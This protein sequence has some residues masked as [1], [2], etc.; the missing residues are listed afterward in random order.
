MDAGGLNQTTISNAVWNTATRSLTIANG[1]I[2]GQTLQAVAILSNLDMTVVATTNIVTFSGAVGCVMVVGKKC[3][4]TVGV[5]NAT[6]FIDLILDGVTSSFDLY[7]GAVGI[8][9]SSQGSVNQLS[10]TGNQVT[11][12]DFCNWQFQMGFN[13]SMTVRVR[14]TATTFTLL[15]DSFTVMWT[16]V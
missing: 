11:I 3:T 15:K 14:I 13:N 2:T 7:D 9:A 6:V 12:G 8:S 1:L 4:A 5:G 10:G 16:H